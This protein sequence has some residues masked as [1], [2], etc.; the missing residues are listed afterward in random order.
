MTTEPPVERGERAAP[1]G[2]PPRDLSPRELG[3]RIKMMRVARGLT[4]KDLEERGGIS[5]THVSE[6]ERGKASPTIGALGRIAS[7]LGLAPAALVEPAV[8]PPVTVLR[9]A[10]RGAHAITWGAARIEAVAPAV[11]DSG[12]AVHLVTLPIGREPALEHDHE[13]EEWVLVLSG[14][15]EIR[16]GE[17]AFVLREGDALHFRAHRPH[18]YANLTSG[19]AVLLAACRPRLAP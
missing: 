15:A 13:G 6:I 16:I 11:Q 17:R 9:A 10:E 1:A 14:A 5:A 7:A 19:P 8:R 12:T 18:R 3:R 4:L 2:F